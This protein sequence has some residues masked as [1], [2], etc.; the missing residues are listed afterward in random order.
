MKTQ[1]TDIFRLIRRGESETVEFK[2]SFGRETLETLCAFANTE[3][4][5]ILIGVNDAG[6][7]TGSQASKTALR[8]WA[9]QIGQGTGL[10]PSIQAAVLS[11]KVVIV[12][13][14]PENHIKPVLFQGRS[15]KR[16]GSTT[17]QMG[18]E[19][20]AGAALSRVGVT[21]DSV[22]ETRAGLSDISISK[23]KAFIAMANREKRRP[24]PAG[25]APME[26]LKKLKLVRGGQPTRAAI[27]LFGKD[28]Q[29]FYS[30][31][32]LKIG[33]FRD[34][35]LIVDDR[36]IDGTLFDQVE[37][38]I[39]YFR[40]KLDTRFEMTGRP[41]R[42]VV[43]EY[44]LKALRE[45]VTNAICHRNYASARDT[46]VRLYDREVMVWNDGGL[47]D[48]LSVQALK[49]AHSSVPRNK[50]IAEIFYYAGMIEQWG[51]GT[52]MILNECKAAGMPEP[53]FEQV[54]GFRV[55]LRKAFQPD[56]AHQQVPD[57]HPTGSIQV[58]Y[59]YH[60][61]T[62]QVAEKRALLD[63]CAAPRSI[64]E[65]LGFLGLKNRVSFMHKRLH[66]LLAEGALAMTDP[67]SPRSP[68]QRYVA[69]ETRSNQ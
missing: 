44:P 52:R 49:K 47:P 11:G 58:P 32:R 56:K 8:D 16:S 21:W 65:M 15:Y 41:Q 30:Q 1:G 67:G 55:T 42:E 33:R 46:E 39:G 35:T 64:K 9:N 7:V 50:Q 12:I 68:R 18:V 38:A 57:K 69:T 61:S 53:V 28:P 63:Y 10:H 40:E 2:Q 24:V 4:G 27:L 25:T 66:P 14:V 54:Q 17:R 59:K 3:G 60:T 20:I 36:R 19:E 48:Q 23:V 31:A 6:V 22:P 43:W 13:R 26:L 5:V 29:E 34:E 62:R 45:A 51:G 37:G